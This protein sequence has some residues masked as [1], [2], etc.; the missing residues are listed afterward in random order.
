ME[1]ERQ[2]FRLISATEDEAKAA[3]DAVLVVAACTSFPAVEIAKAYG[4][5]IAYGHRRYTKDE[6]LQ[7]ARDAE[8]L[9]LPFDVALGL[10]APHA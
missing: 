10:S 7:V 4:H 3:F 1:R 2:T 5:H 6:L 8:R 9:H